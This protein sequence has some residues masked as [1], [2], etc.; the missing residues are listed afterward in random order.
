M[1]FKSYTFISYLSQRREAEHLKASAVC[2][3]GT[4]PVHE[5]MKSAEFFDYFM[6]WPEI[7]MIGVSEDYFSAKFF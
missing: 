2:E 5:L 6:S 3:N 4:V 7:K 1:R